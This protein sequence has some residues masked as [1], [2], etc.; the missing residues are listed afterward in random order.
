MEGDQVQPT[1][2]S[3]DEYTRFKQWVQDVH[4]TTRGHLSTEI[5]NALREYRQPDD[6]SKP[7]QRI[8]DDVATIKAQLAEVESDGGGAV[9]DSPDDARTH[10]HAPNTKPSANAPRA[11]KVAWIAEHGLSDTGEMLKKHVAGVVQDEFH[12]EER[13]AKKY[14]DGVLSELNAEQHPENDRIWVWGE[15]KQEYDNMTYGSEE[16]E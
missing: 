15:L 6:A 12:F 4:G 5:E 9:P 1:R 14:V 16:G 13:T 11:E 3:K 8:E 10:T 7:L 2:I